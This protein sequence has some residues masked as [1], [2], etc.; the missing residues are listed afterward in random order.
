MGFWLAARCTQTWVNSCSRYWCFSLAACCSWMWVGLAW[1][2]SCNN[3][4]EFIYWKV[5]Y[6]VCRMRWLLCDSL[7][8]VYIKDPVTWIYS[9]PLTSLTVISCLQDEGH[10]YCSCIMWSGQTVIHTS[11]AKNVILSL[12]C[13]FLG[14]WFYVLYV[15]SSLSLDH[16]LPSLWPVEQD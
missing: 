1:L 3:M 13:Y 5:A 16:H 15:M 11:S 10:H 8:V 7:V 14:L 4:V 6:K 2:Y 9:L 12:S